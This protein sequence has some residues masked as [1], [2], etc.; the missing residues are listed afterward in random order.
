MYNQHPE[1]IS[2]QH[3]MECLKGHYDEILERG[4]QQNPIPE[5]EKRKRGKPKKGKIC[6]LIDRLFEHKGEVCRFA[7][8]PLVPFTNN[9]AERD[10]RMV[11]MKNKV[12]GTFRSEQGA[13]DFLIL[14]SF[15]STAVKNGFTA[16]DALRSLLYGHF[17][18]VTE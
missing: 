4:V 9:Q 10:L 7:D 16:F 12:I 17:A 11:K 8:N 13:K 1:I 14:K 3:Y 15:T 18:L 2:R 6:A 5:K